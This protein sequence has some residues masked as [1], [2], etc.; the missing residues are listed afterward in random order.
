MRRGRTGRL[1]ATIGLT[2][3]ALLFVAAPA[4]ADSTAKNECS[5]THGSDT[6]S[7]ANTSPG[8]YTNTCE[9]EHEPG[10]GSETGNATGQPCAGCV[11]NADDK[12]PPGQ[13]PDG[14]DDNNGY[15]C[16]GNQG[17]GKENPAHTGCY[18]LNASHTV[19]ASGLD[20]AKKASAERAVS[21]AGTN[22]STN[23]V[24]ATDAALVGGMVLLGAAVTVPL[25][26]RRARQSGQ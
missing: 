9:P 1:L 4:H 25:R 17:V 24:T 20:G 21:D 3:A 16:D 7:G 12:Q 26:R 11:G 22:A 19:D 15:E 5:P 14:S 18:P 8:P 6:G 13:F 2:G 23:P 10:N